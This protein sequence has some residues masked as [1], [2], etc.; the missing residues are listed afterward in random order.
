M[1]APVESPA[2]FGPQ[3]QCGYRHHRELWR[4]PQAAKRI[5][6]IAAYCFDR[7]CDIRLVR[8]FPCKR[9]IA[10]PS[11]GVVLRLFSSHSRFLVG[12]GTRLQ[13]KLHLL[14]EFLVNLVAVEQVRDSVKPAY[15]NLL[16]SQTEHTCYGFSQL[17]PPL[18]LLRQLPASGDRNRVVACAPIVV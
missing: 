8:P 12:A 1:Q 10:E 16:L 4:L 14:F 2:A 5:A 17:G 3:R 18:G 7:Q 11:S 9:G 13:V 15:V 6:Q